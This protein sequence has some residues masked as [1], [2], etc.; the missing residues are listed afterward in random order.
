MAASRRPR[1]FTEIG[2]T[3]SEAE[4]ITTP[5]YPQTGIRIPSEDAAT[6]ATAI[7]TSAEATPSAEARRR[8]FIERPAA[9][10]AA[11]NLR[12]REM[13][14]REVPSVVEASLG[15]SINANPDAARTASASAPAMRVTR[16]W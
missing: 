10:K 13:R 7:R 8:V 14:R 15:A 6:A 2:K 1:P 12:I 4:S 11:A 16:S 3:A 9:A 5:G